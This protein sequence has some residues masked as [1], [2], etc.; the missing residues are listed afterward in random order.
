MNSIFYREW[1]IWENI[2][3]RNTR[4]EI[5]GH[6]EC[7]I[8]P[9]LMSQQTVEFLAEQY[10]IRRNGVTKCQPCP[11]GFAKNQIISQEGQLCL[12]I[13]D[14][15][16]HDEEIKT[17]ILQILNNIDAISLCVDTALICQKIAFYGDNDGLIFFATRRAVGRGMS[18]EVDERSKA[19]EL[20]DRAFPQ[21]DSM[22]PNIRRAVKFYLNGLTLLGL[23]DQV[24]G[25]LNAAFMQFY[26]G[27]E[28]VTSNSKKA[29]VCKCIAKKDPKDSRDLQI[30][31]H[32]VWQV[33]N[34]YFGHG[35]NERF[36][37]LNK[38]Y[39]A[40]QR[41]MRQVLVARYLCK[42]LIDIA[43][44]KENN[45]IREMRFYFGTGSICFLGNVADLSGE[46]RMEYHGRNVKIYDNK[47]NIIDDFT[48]K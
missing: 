7:M 6:F 14:S 33:R 29:E 12:K 27:C 17:I 23:E 41:I 40:S 5:R 8:L 42:R 4:D 25:V 24:P 34:D 15:V 22:E 2:I 39:T 31:V 18:F 28:A 43:T 47:G 45:L 44:S 9:T 3:R 20:L 10:M 26:Q 1:D 38:D 21:L 13:Y 46:F 30:I 16:R 11:P 48:I 32:H 19:V 37:R 36:E 35:W